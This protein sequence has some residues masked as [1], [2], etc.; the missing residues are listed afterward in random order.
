LK[1]AQL[2]AHNN[3]VLIRA[4]EQLTNHQESKKIGDLVIN[5]SHRS[6]HTATNSV[7]EIISQPPAHTANTPV[8]VAPVAASPLPTQ[9]KT[10]TQSA[11]IA[12]EGSAPSTQAAEQTSLVQGKPA[13]SV[14]LPVNAAQQP[15][16]ITTIRH[17]G[18]GLNTTPNVRAGQAPSAS[19][20]RTALSASELRGEINR[21]KNKPLLRTALDKSQENYDLAV[22]YLN[23][24]DRGT[25]EILLR[26]LETT[27][28][29]EIVQK[30]TTLLS[31]LKSH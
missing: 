1:K 16:P 30:A 18:L 7:P 29:P 31:Q 22:V 3:Q 12:A 5:P 28:H 6:L 2:N 23:M 25:A 11:N 26:E 27:G 14:R 13:E 24:G 10:T 8:A 19:A 4:L 9:D 17:S 15:T 20:Q 21:P